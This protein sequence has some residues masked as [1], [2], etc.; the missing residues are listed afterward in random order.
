MFNRTLTV[1]VNENEKLTD[2]D[3]GKI[4]WLSDDECHKWCKWLWKFDSRMPT[5]FR[6]TNR[7]WTATEASKKNGTNLLGGRIGPQ[8]CYRLGRRDF[9][10]TQV[11][12]DCLRNTGGNG[13][14][15]WFQL[16]EKR[17]GMGLSLKLRK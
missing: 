6:G 9:L 8:A 11:S 12:D 10:E 14:W 16:F 5:I 13:K 7:K 2:I 17:L 15:N 3:G 4:E 1:T